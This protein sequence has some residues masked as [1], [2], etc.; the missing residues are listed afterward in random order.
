M[1]SE[2]LRG[3][4]A[5]LVADAEVFG[6]LVEKYG[7]AKAK[8]ARIEPDELDRVGLAYTIVNLYS[9]MESYFLRVAKFFEND[10]D[11][12]SWHRDLV[13]RMTLSI[14]GIRPAVLSE[15]EARTIDELRAFR[16]VFRHMYQSELD[17]DKLELVE[18]RTP[19]AIAAFE[20]AHERLLAI[21]RALLEEVEKG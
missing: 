20:A 17:P 1:K 10:I 16:H 5:E 4:Q 14:E 7:L 3:L 11:R 13:R 21:L 19:R 9:L 8:L 2:R 18:S 12:S 6:R 15:E